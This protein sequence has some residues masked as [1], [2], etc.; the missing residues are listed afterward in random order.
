MFQSLISIDEGANQDISTVLPEHGK[1]RALPRL[2][3]PARRN[4][5]LTGNANNQ[6]IGVKYIDGR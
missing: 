3:F 2:R 5:P 4:Y 1:P 6:I